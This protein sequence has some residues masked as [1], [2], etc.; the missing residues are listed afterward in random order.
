M[1]GLD[2]NVLVRYIVRDDAAQTALA[3]EL[4][5]SKCTDADPGF[6]S[7]LVLIELFWVLSRGYGYAKPILVEVLSRLLASAEMDIEAVSEAWAALQMYESGA[8]DFADY[9]IGCRGRSSGCEV[10]YTFDRRAS[11]SALFRLVT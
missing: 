3:T 9:L 7:Q 2:T 10:T 5:E 8:A 1:I 11:D 6:V 4:I